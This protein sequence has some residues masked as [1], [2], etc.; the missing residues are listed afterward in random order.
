MDPR[1]ASPGVRVSRSPV[2][3]ERRVSKMEIIA[4][5]DAERCHMR[6]SCWYS[7]TAPA[8]RRRAQFAMAEVFPSQDRVQHLTKYA[9]PPDPV[10]GG[11]RR[12]SQAQSRRPTQTPRY[13]PRSDSFICI[14]MCM[15]FALRLCAQEVVSCRLQKTSVFASRETPLLTP[16]TKTRYVISELI[17]GVSRHGILQ[18]SLYRIA[19]EFSVEPTSSFIRIAVE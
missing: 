6:Y 17:T 8:D 9:F 3:L 2:E 10:M 7:L 11:G 13:T 5:L 14:S 1:T 12:A 4:C 18:F 15:L 19:M 16:R